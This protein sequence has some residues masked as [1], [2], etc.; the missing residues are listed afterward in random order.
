MRARDL[1]VP[2]P[3]VAPST[4]V[5]EALRAMIESRLPGVVVRD[6]RAF[7]VV[8]ASQVLRVVLPPYV[9]ADPSLGRV[10][11]ESSADELVARA[12]GLTV[13][14]LLAALPEGGAAAT[15]D[16]DA[17]AVEIAA[18]LSSAHVPLVAVI[19]RDELVGVVS[20]NR[21]AEALLA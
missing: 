8:P 5:P 11:D 13:R 7:T 9:L 10:W 6:D 4:P 15:V 18:V 21:L 2:A 20:V 1:M 12:R 14:D 17:T 16:P 3:T 19:D